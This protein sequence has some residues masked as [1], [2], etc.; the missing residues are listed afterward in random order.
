MQ[1][2]QSTSCKVCFKCGVEKPLT[3]FYKHKAMA[4]GHL[5]KCKECTK[6]DATKNRNENIEEY[7]AYD[8]ERGARQ[9]KSYLP[10]YRKKYPK[11]Y[12]AHNAV[13]NAIRDG[14][15]EKGCCEV[16]GAV[17]AVA[18][19]DDY[20]KPMDIRWLCQAHHK[21]WHSVHGEALNAV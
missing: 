4:D 11:K 18:H 8:R 6:K 5:N 10:D 3:E 15:I 12:K 16:C 7:R 9:D 21:Q 1:D 19:H 14:K 2:T 20:D 17:K 13:N